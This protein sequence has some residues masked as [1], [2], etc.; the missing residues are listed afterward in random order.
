MPWLGLGTWQLRSGRIA[1]RAVRSALDIGYRLIDTAKLYGNEADVG[2]AIRGSGIPRDEIFVTTKLWNSDHGYDRAMKAFHRSLDSL[3]L[4]YVDLYLIHWPESGARAETWRALER[5]CKEGTAKAI[6]VSNY[7]VRHLAEMDTYASIPPAVNQVEFSPF[8]FQRD[9]L[10]DCRKRGIQL[11]AYS[12]LTKGHRLSDPRLL[13]LAS[14]YRKTPAQILLRWCL[15]HQVVAIP[16]SEDRA[17]QTEDADIFGF[18]LNAE[19][20]ARLDRIGD[21][22]RTS[23]DPTFVP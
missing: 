15:E 3:G 20:M 11:E 12:P 4:G 17:R 23:W 9:L 5:I 6:G 8:L 2:R 1:E 10:E 14:K 22:Y 21:S 16:K 13:E 7:T 19:D 18:E